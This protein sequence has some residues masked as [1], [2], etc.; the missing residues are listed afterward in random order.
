MN[1]FDEMNEIADELRANPLHVPDDDLIA[2]RQL[3]R[4]RRPDL[5]VAQFRDLYAEWRDHYR[6]RE[7]VQAAAR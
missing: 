3:Q 6:A 4:H 5:S 7:E 2:F 1:L